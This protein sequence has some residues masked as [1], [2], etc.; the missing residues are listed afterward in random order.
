METKLTLEKCKQIHHNMW[1]YVKK[2]DSCSGLYDRAKVKKL[3]CDKQNLDLLNHCALC[4]YAKQQCIQNNGSYD[5]EFLCRYCPAI[6][7]TE[8]KVRAYYCELADG[9]Y[10]GEEVLNWMA[11]PC[12]DIINIKWKDEIK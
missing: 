5:D 2:F 12:D 7:G 8:D 3:F 9:V 10:K 6:W 11:S 1:K 4:E